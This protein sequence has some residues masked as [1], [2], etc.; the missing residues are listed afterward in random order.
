M[1]DALDAL[2]LS[3]TQWNYT[4]SNRNDA[5]IGD[6]WNQEDLSIWSADQIEDPADP[7]AGVRALHG[8]CRPWV[9]AAQGILVSQVFNGSD[10]FECVIDVDPDIAADTEI[11]VPAHLE[12]V[13]LTTGAGVWDWRREH[14][15]MLARLPSGRQVVE[16]KLCVSSPRL[17]G[18]VQ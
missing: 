5:M 12:I 11:F 17:S 13:S 9:R 10:T 2:L 8:F 4:A 3:S 14:G 6:G 15:R 7:D 18:A 16:L 1:Y